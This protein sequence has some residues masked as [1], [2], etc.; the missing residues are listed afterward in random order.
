[1]TDD[2]KEIL[3]IDRLHNGEKV[4]CEVFNKGYM[5]PYNTSADKAHGFIC[6]NPDCNNRFHWDPV[7]NLE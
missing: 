2:G 5:A 3:L 1:M 7:I 6:T 4:K